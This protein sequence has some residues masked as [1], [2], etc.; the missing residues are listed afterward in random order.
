MLFDA[1][2]KEIGEFGPWQILLYV[3]LGL[4]GIPT[5]KSKCI[6][7]IMLCSL[8]NYLDDYIA[9]PELPGV[10][11]GKQVTTARTYDS[12]HYPGRSW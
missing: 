1:I 3:L 9:L 8:W 4:V 10:A 11:R 12:L 5:G 7:I 6:S 2:L